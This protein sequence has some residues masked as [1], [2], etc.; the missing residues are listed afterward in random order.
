MIIYFDM[1]GV[2]CDFKGRIL[3]LYGTEFKSDMWMRIC[4]DYPRIY[5]GLNSNPTMIGLI[6]ELCKTNKVKIL[7][8]KPSLVN[9]RYCEEDKREWCKNN[10][11]EEVEVIVCE[12]AMNKQNYAVYNSVPNVLIDDSERN[13]AQW[14]SKG[15]IGLLYNF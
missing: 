11:L 9:F 10:G 13:I 15:G 14:R 1:D 5:K 2:L 3:E 12:K 4:T 6:K 7:T 8:A